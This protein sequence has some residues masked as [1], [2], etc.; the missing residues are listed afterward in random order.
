MV[1]VNVKVLP[2]KIHGLGVFAGQF[3]PKGAIIWRYTSGFDLKYSKDEISKL[4][5]T[6]QKYLETYSW[7]S[8]KS[9]KYVFESISKL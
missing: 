8:K 3:I 4:P 5:A 2:S 9:D 1:C 7:L 6:A